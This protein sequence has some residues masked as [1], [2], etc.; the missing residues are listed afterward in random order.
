MT[1]DYHLVVET[2]AANLSDGMQYLNGLYA[3]RFNHRH[4][5]SGHLFQGR[6]HA[7]LLENT[8]HPLAAVR[9]VAR[10]PVTA[11]LCST[12]GEWNWSA[13]RRLRARAQTG[14]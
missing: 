11:Q 12:P 13:H 3:Q 6:F 2:P 9:Y 5:R 7:G 8:A 14:S 10:N 4:G 1:T